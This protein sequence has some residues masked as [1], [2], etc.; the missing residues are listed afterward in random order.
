MRFQLFR[1]KSI[2]QLAKFTL[3]KFKDF[4]CPL[5]PCETVFFTTLLPKTK[6]VAFPIKDFDDCPRP[7]AEHKEIACEDIKVKMVRICMDNPFT[8]LRISVAPSTM[9]TC[10]FESNDSIR[11]Q[12]P[13]EG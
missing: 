1:V 2:Q 9:N 3:A 11:R 7:I 5:R 4:F 10:V 12:L 6:F 13:V 8:T